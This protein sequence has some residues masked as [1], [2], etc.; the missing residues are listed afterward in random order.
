M[1][2]TYRTVWTVERA[3]SDVRRTWIDAAYARFQSGGLGDVRVELLA[4]DIGTTKGS[5]YWHF[6]NRRSLV[7]AVMERWEAEQT[8]AIISA[9]EQAGNARGRLSRLF[10]AVAD[11]WSKRGGEATLYVSAQHEGVGAFVSRVTQRRSDY[12]TDLLIE[13]GLGAAEARRRSTIALAAVVGLQHLSIVSNSA[14]TGIDRDALT[15]TALAMCTA[16]LP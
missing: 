15:A 3:T 16:G 7:D 6:R 1:A 11:D 9:A 13:L 2:A 5:F 14:L 4:R 10:S 12:V 8:E